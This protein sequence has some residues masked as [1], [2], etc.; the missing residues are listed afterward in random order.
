MLILSISFQYEGQWSKGCVNISTLGPLKGFS[1]SWKPCLNLWSQRWQK[2]N[3]SLTT[4]HVI[5]S[6]ANKFYR[7]FLEKKDVDFELKKLMSW[8]LHSSMVG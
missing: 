5:W 1:A 3:H 7:T 4:E 6:R 8:L 2:P